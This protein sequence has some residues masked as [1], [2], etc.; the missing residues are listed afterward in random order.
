[1]KLKAL[2]QVHVSSVSA[3]TIPAGTVFD[4]SDALADDLLKRLP[5]MFERAEPAP[6]NKAERPTQ[7]KAS[8]SGKKAAE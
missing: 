6:K 5:T 1:M 3:N 4:C 2:D 7:N 8:G